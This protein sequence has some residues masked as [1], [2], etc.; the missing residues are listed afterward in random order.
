MAALVAGIT[1]GAEQTLHAQPRGEPP[2]N[3]PMQLGPLVLAPVLRLTDV[4][5]DSNVLN[6]NVD[7]NPQ[8]DYTTTFIPSVEAW[9]RLPRMRLNGRGQLNFYYFK[10]LTD[11]RAMDSD[12]AAR[13]EV[14]LNRLIPYVD[15]ALADTR[16]Q[17]NLE[18]DAIARRRDESLTAGADVRFSD[19]FFAGGY[20]RRGSLEY[21]EDELYLGTDLAR[22]L[23]HTSRGEGIAFRYL[24]TPFSTFTVEVENQRDRFDLSPERDSDSFSVLPSVTFSPF[25]LIS[26]R[27]S[28]GYQHREFLSG[29]QP[30]FSGTV[31]FVD[32]NYTLLGRTRFTV[33]A[34]RQLEYSYLVGQYQY[35]DA[36]VTGTVVQRLA[37][38]WDIGGSLGRTTLTYSQVMTAGDPAAPLYPDETILT[39]SGNVGYNVGRA[40]IGFQVEQRRRAAGGAGTRG[41]ER[42][43]IGSTVTYVF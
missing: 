2:A 40:R 21:E 22:V 35:V 27:A 8:G 30:D 4:G 33:E 11:L 18:I 3:P 25:A 20:A 42:F 5:Y 28:I 32:L 29:T 6:L 14:P 38:A 7:D 31:A 16:H 23:N 36:G 43:R 1:L 37:D 17:R 24:A 34:H 15:G 10:E 9:L 26:G 13:L 19:K 12:M 41:Y 39:A